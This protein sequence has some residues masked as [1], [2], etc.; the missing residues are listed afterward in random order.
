MGLSTTSAKRRLDANSGR[1]GL[2]TCRHAIRRLTTSDS[3]PATGPRSVCQA[4]PA[5]SRLGKINFKLLSEVFI[6]VWA[7][8]EICWTCFRVAAETVGDERGAVDIRPCRGALSVSGAVEFRIIFSF[9]FFQSLI[10][11]PKSHPNRLD[12]NRRVFLPRFVASMFLGLAPSAQFATRQLPH[13][14]LG[15]RSAALEA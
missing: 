12:F 13:T 1:S 9:I 15:C 8:R 6:D 7:G 3:D 14:S 2:V 5:I 10:S 4:E 11:A